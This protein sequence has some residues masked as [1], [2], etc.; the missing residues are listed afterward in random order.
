MPSPSAVHITLVY[1]RNKVFRDTTVSKKGPPKI[2]FKQEMPPSSHT[3]PASTP[4]EEQQRKWDK[5]KLAESPDAQ[6]SIN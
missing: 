4:R 3:Q 6:E 5:R 1:L 2:V